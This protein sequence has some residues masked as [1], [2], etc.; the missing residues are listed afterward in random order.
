M[1]GGNFLQ[2]LGLVALLAGVVAARGK[3][4]ARLGVDGRGQLAL[5]QDALLL[6]QDVRGGNRRQQRLGVGVDRH[7]EQLL[8]GAGLHQ[9]AQ[10]HD[11]DVSGDVPHDGQ[12]VGDEHV[13]Q[14]LLLLQVL[15][16]VED[17][18][19]DGHV[20][21]GDRLVAD[22]EGGIQRDGARH[23]DTLTAA[24][25]QLV[26]VGIPQALVQADRCH[27]GLGPLDDLRLGETLGADQGLLHRLKHGHA[28][29]EGGVGVLEDDLHLLAQLTQLFLVDVGDVLAVEEDL[30]FGALQQVDHGTAQGGLAAA[31][32]AD[33][34]HGGALGNG[35]SHIVH[36]VELAVGGIKIFLEV[37][38]LDHRGIHSI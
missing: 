7:A 36:R 26:G 27:D 32:L 9:L 8:G 28:G 10:V 11:T 5:E 3:A 31:G 37:S 33:D 16:E 13:G 22:D 19:L 21:R 12:V 17:L 1:S 24:T 25:V 20:Q 34:A 38:C 2:L 30:A 29:V 6:V 35:E 14:A 15:H 4:A 18:G 23:T